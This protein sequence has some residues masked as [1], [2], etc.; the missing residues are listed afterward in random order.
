MALKNIKKH[1]YY[2]K[3]KNKY[4][5]Y[6]LIKK[7]FLKILFKTWN[8][9]NFPWF[10][11]RLDELNWPNNL[12]WIERGVFGRKYIEKEDKVL[13]LCCGD[14]YFSIVFYSSVENVQIDAIDIDENVLELGKMCNTNK[15]IKFYQKDILKDIFPLKDYDVILFFEAIEHFAADDFS[16]IAKKINKCLKKGGY[17]IGSTP[18]VSIKEV[19]NWQHQNEFSN[20]DDLKNFLAKYFNNVDV[21]IT[22]HPE[23]ITAYFEVKND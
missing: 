23:R 8:S 12:F 7:F 9:F 10:D 19:G 22:E 18:L 16:I 1:D 13:D 5:L 11:H 15:C 20:V 17:L 3:T 14:G 2:N 21:W 4:K 6:C